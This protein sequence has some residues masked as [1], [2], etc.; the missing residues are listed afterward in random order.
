MK[1]EDTKEIIYVL[2]CET[3]K[4]YINYY[5]IQNSEIFTYLLFRIINSNLKVYSKIVLYI[6]CMTWHI[7]L[8][9][10]MREFF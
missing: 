7:T 3:K 6:T 10:Y 2:Y 9:D 1:A 4:K 8:E 5:T